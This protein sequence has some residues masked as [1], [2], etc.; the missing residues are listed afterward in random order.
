MATSWKRR[1]WR[2]RRHERP[3]VFELLL[4]RGC[5]AKA[6][7]D[8]GHCVLH[9]LPTH[10]ALHHQIDP[11]LARGLSVDADSRHGRRPLMFALMRRSAKGARILIEHGADIHKPDE[12]GNTPLMVLAGA[13]L[14]SVRAQLEPELLPLFRDLLQNGVELETRNQYGET[15]LHL[16]AQRGSARFV[17]LL[18]EH[19]ANLEAE[20]DL[21]VTALQLAASSKRGAEMA[22]HL[23]GLGAQL[24]FFSAICLDREAEVA[25]MLAA[26][27][28]LAK[29]VHP[30]R[31][32][33]AIARAVHHASFETVEL[34]LER[35]ADPR[36]PPVHDSIL[37]CAIEDR[38]SLELLGLLLRHGAEVD[39]LSSAGLPALA[40]AAAH[41]RLDMAELLLA[42]GADP[43]LTWNERGRTVLNS[44]KTSEM[45]ALLE[46]HGAQ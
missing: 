5:C 45:T 20:T 32:G 9:Y 7:D 28:E 27:P 40:C 14:S 2:R 39:G 24:D 30:G 29:M 13:V 3:E 17:S 25:R 37:H 12:R 42:K 10:E 36:L 6:T 46:R 23:L 16:A 15:A 11:M 1:Y 8:W 21:R 26:D 43:N 4:E 41:G 33:S 35:G 22:E 34:L 44:A 18:A 31:L 38:K 19:G